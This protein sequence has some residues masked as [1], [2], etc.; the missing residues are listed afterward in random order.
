MFKKSKAQ[1]VGQTRQK[2]ANHMNNHKYD[3]AHFSDTFTN[4]S[5]QFNSAGHSIPDFSFMPVDKVT[6]DWKWLLKET[7]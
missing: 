7:T 1:Y 6:N 4:V 3:I 2:C 5:E